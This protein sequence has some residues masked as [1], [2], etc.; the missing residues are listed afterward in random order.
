M[1]NPKQQQPMKLVEQSFLEDE[2]NISIKQELDTKYQQM[3]MELDHNILQVN[4]TFTKMKDML[5]SIF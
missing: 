3:K 2:D 4:G 1:Y 5:K